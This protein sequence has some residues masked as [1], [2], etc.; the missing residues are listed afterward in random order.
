MKKNLFMVAA[1][2]LMAMISCN[3]E[4]MNIGGEPQVPE[5]L[6]PSLDK[7]NIIKVGVRCVESVGENTHAGGNVGIVLDS[8]IAWMHTIKLHIARN[9]VLAARKIYTRK[10]NK[11]LTPSSRH[12]DA[13]KR[14]EKQCA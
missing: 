9:K 10:A 1:V 13:C 2:A 11:D 7:V 3:K 8:Y 5:V 4:E 12:R 6:Q 14:K